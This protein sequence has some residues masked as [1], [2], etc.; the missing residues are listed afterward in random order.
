[1]VEDPPDPP[2]PP[3]SNGQ[4]C[5]NTSVVAIRTTTAPFNAVQR[6]WGGSGSGSICYDSWGFWYIEYDFIQCNAG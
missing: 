3:P 2:E 1:M 6:C 5:T 4:P